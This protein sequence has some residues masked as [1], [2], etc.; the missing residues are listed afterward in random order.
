MVDTMIFANN[1]AAIVTSALSAAATSLVLP[2]G[3][4][5]LFPNPGA[6]EY[7]KL[8]LE[9]RRIDPVKREIVHCTSRSTDTLTIVRGQESTSAQAFNAGFVA[10]HRL[11]AAAMNLLSQN[12]V[13][14]NQLWLGV[15]ATDPVVGNDGGP[16]AQGMLYFNSVDNLNRTYDG[17]QWRAV[18]SPEPGVTDRLFYTATGGQTDFGHTTD[19]NGNTLN[20]TVAYQEIVHVFKNGLALIWP[21]DFTINH[22]ANRIVLTSPAALND[23]VQLWQISPAYLLSPVIKVAKPLRN[24]DLDPG[25]GTPGYINGSRAVFKLRDAANSPVMPTDGYQI[26]VFLDGVRQQN[27]VDYTVATDE[28]TFDENLPAG[29]RFFGEF[30][31]L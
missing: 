23:K 7:F 29:T 16:L 31:S 21:T 8:T 24:I 12:A 3:K 1:A 6:N 13:N 4:G 20:L 15:H 22:A 9:D 28:I 2:S 11:T 17:T 14:F 10:S 26:E 27:T 30:Y 25:T 19:L 18:L 5:A